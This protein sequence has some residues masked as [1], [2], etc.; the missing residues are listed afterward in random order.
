LSGPA[1]DT[2]EGSFYDLFRWLFKRTSFG[3]PFSGTPQRVD[4]FNDD[5]PELSTSIIIDEYPA[6]ECLRELKPLRLRVWSC[7]II[8]DEEY[9]EWCLIMK[10]TNISKKWKFDRLTAEVLYL[11]LAVMD[12]V[13]FIVEG[14]SRVEVLRCIELDKFINKTIA[15][16][17][18]GLIAHRRVVHNDGIKAFI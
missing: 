8:L 12:D 13:T 18:S 4:H 6:Q 3:D 9:L 2:L 5:N 11:V 10:S 15:E 1:W 16:T 14:D 7:L 17:R